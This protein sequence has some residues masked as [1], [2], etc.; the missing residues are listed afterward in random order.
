MGAGHE[1]TSEW[2]LANA[3]ET[4]SRELRP[5][6]RKAYRAESYE[7]RTAL[8]RDALLPAWSVLSTVMFAAEG[9]DAAR[10]I[11]DA[12]RPLLPDPLARPGEQR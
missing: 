8:A 7:D 2:A 1:V 5:V 4:M 3:L 9:E 10:A 11:S 6:V 12:L